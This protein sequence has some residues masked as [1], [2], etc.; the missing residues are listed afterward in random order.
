MKNPD[1]YYNKEKNKNRRDTSDDIY[2]D[3]VECSSGMIKQSIRNHDNIKTK[4]NL[5]FK[6]LNMI[7]TSSY[8]FYCGSIHCNVG[9]LNSDESALIRLRFRLWSRHLAIVNTFL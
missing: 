4:S 3:N 1:K 7:S 5:N 9:P 6:Y 8:N 2:F